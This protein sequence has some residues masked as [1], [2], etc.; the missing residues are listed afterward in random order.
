MHLEYYAL[1]SE[2]S[3]HELFFCPMLPIDTAE[4]SISSA[5]SIYAKDVARDFYLEHY[6]HTMPWPQAFHIW[7]APDHNDI[8]KGNTTSVDLGV[9]SVDLKSEPTFRRPT[10]VPQVPPA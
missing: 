3:R 7:I 4:P 6:G 2:G 5:S 1:T 10:R 9:W 8:V